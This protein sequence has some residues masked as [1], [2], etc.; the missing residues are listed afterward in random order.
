MLYNGQNVLPSNDLHLSEIKYLKKQPEY[1]DFTVFQLLD[2]HLSDVKHYFFTI[3]KWGEVEEDFIYFEFEG[4]IWQWSLIENGVCKVT[5]QYRIMYYSN[6]FI[7][8]Q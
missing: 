5:N 4:D 7:K 8:M 6:K 1:K 3:N 2:L